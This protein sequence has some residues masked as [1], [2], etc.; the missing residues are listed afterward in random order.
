MFRINYR[1]PETMPRDER[2]FPPRTRPEEMRGTEGSRELGLMVAMYLVAFF[3]GIF[4][5][6]YL[7][8]PTTP[9]AVTAEIL[10]GR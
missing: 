6:G 7:T 1:P 5:L 10:A 9:R 2:D 4:V 3:G 8:T